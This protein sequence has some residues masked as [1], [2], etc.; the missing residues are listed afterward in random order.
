M[1]MVDIVDNLP[2]EVKVDVKHEVKKGVQ[3]SVQ[4]ESA[5]LV[6]TILTCGIY[7]LVV[8]VYRSC[9]PGNSEGGGGSDG[10]GCC[11]CGGCECEIC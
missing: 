10:D 7:A 8:G 9:S 11:G 1:D 4:E 2:R 5:A 3:Q 6:C